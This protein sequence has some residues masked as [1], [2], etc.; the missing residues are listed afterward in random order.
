VSLVWSQVQL[1]A[2][3]GEGVEVRLVVEGIG[4]RAV[5][6]VQE[7]KVQGERA[8]A[9]VGRDLRGRGAYP[10]ELLEEDEIRLEDRLQTIERIMSVDNPNWRHIAAGSPVGER[11]E[12]TRTAEIR[13]MK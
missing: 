7:I 11:L 6:L 12:D 3:L 8:P 9:V 2:Y 4:H 10:A 13:R 5:L 1:I